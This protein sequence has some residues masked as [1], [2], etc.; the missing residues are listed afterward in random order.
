MSMQSSLHTNVNTRTV[1]TAFPP[2]GDRSQPFVTVRI[3]TPENNVLLFFND[4]HNI[5]QVLEALEIAERLLY[6]LLKEPQED[7][8]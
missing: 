4:R 6:D 2:D 1:A 5:I 3:G 8:A 7:G